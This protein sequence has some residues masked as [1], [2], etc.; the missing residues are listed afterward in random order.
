[1]SSVKC[2]TAFRINLVRPND[3]KENVTHIV[4]LSSKTNQITQRIIYKEINYMW[5]LSC[6]TFD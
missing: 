1:M 4:L 5:D 3:S 6:P 2:R